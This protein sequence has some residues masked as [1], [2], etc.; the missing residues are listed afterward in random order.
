MLCCLTFCGVAWSIVVYCDVA[1]YV[2]SCYVGGVGCLWCGVL[3]VSTWCVVWVTYG[4]VLCGMLRCGVAWRGL[5][6]SVVICDVLRRVGVRIM[7][8]LAMPTV[9]LNIDRFSKDS[10]NRNV[11]LSPD[12]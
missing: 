9:A 7:A 6:S 5:I 4:A 8:T 1:K 11:C 3:Q 10:V 2:G 12:H